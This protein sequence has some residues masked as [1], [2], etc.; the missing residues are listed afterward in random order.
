MPNYAIVVAGGAGTRMGT[1]IAKQFLVV[2][3]KPVLM[4]TLQKFETCDAIILVLPATQISYWQKLCV[5]YD[6]T[7]PHTVVEGG[8]ERFNS[9]LNG[10]SV[11]PHEGV[12]AIHDGVRPC[13][14]KAIIEQSFTDATVYKSAVA[15]V[16]L[17]DSIRMIDADKTIAVDRNK[18][19]LVQTPQTFLL[20]DIKQA[21]LQATSTNFTDD[22]AVF[23]AAGHTIH[24][25]AG[26]YKN[27]KIT[28]PED[29]PLAEL[30]LS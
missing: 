3:N 28:T 23:E 10:L 30:F 19:Y 17:K 11:L 18:Y 12:V 14:S 13:I 5:D 1:D 7:L 15:A 22:A 27:I 16:K 26:D 20:A 8:Q 4:H 21:Y 6:F 2:K 29:L 24:L 25:I 9:V